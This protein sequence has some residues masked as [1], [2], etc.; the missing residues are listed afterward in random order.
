MNAD[1][2]P[3][4]IVALLT[5]F[6][7]RDHYVGSVRG[8]VLSIAPNAVLADITHETNPHDIRSAGF[9]LWA[10]Y[11]DFPAGTVFLCV[12]DPGVGSARRRIILRTENYLFVAP[13][14]GLLTFVMETEMTWD[15]FE[16]E[17]SQ[18]FGPTISGTFDG[19]DVFGPVAAHL[20]N[21]VPG[22]RIGRP[23]EGPVR[24]RTGMGAVASGNSRI[25][26]VVAVDR[27][28]N[29]ITGLDAS[30]LISGAELEIKGTRISEIR[31]NFTDGPLNGP[32]LIA[33]S[34]GLAEIAC[35]RSSASRLLAAGV[36]EP[37]VLHL[38]DVRFDQ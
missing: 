24:I 18:Y 8:A 4:K 37:V 36:G 19:R 2:G 34:S 16:I 35:D 31:R 3:A 14:N 20:A 29:L 25:A 7:L 17:N 15:A 13:D 38:P 1:P 33:G 6:G 5:D 30:L 28:G 26:E 22:E 10:C 32:F 27:F 12:V 21:G 11:R 9:S 23:L